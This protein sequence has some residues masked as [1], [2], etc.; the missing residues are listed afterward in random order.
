MIFLGCKWAKSILASRFI[1]DL[2]RGLCESSDTKL[3][4]SETPS[5]TEWDLPT[6]QAGPSLD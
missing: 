5:S 3:R 1:L 2:P 4:I 6:L